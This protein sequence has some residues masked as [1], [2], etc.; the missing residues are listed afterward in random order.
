MSAKKEDIKAHASSFN[1]NYYKEV[2][3]SLKNTHSFIFYNEI[4][5]FNKFVLLRHDCD[6]SINRAYKIAKIENNLSLKSTYFINPHCSYYNIFEKDQF[7]LVSKIHELGHD[8]GLHFDSDFH[9]IRSEDQLDEKIRLEASIVEKFFPFS[10]KA[11]SFHNPT[12]FLLN[13]NSSSYGGLIN[14]YS[15][16]IMKD[17]KYCSD[18]NGYW[19][20]DSL[21]D[22][23]KNNINENLHILTHPGWWQDKVMQPRERV[24]R[25]LTGRR[26]RILECYDELLEKFNR[27]NIY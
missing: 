22:F 6:L 26:D 15:K 2:L 8:I 9:D 7:L 11:F 16:Q 14:T 18:S 27:E 5:D 23:I 13:C 19:R 4:K 20:H 3:E 21:K 12:E 10:L 17:T 25:S 24:E 1:L